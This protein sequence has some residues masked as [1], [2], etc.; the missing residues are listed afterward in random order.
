MTP[1]QVETA[2]RL[3]YNSSSSTFWSSDELRKIIWEGEQI[4]ATEA[5][6]IEDKDTS[7]STVN[8]TRAYALPSLYIGIK[9][10]EINGVKLQRIDDRDDDRLTL[11]NSATTSTG[12]PMYYWEWD[13]YIY[14]R[15]IP[16]E[17]QTV[18]IFGWKEATLLDSSSSTLATPVRCHNSLIYWVAHNMA[19][20]DENYDMADYY[21]RLW[22]KDVERHKAWTAKKKRTDA[23]AVVKD[24]ESASVTI[25]GSV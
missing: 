11:N 25:L 21:L 14:L 3:R 4:L 12:Q 22:D 13:D 18:T 7:I 6:V 9:R 23:F 20:K 24:E 5:K 16:A 19:L 1:A 17:A 8:G 15:P 2:A 10:I